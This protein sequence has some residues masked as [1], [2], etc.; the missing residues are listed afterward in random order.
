ML[1]EKNWKG[2]FIIKLIQWS[3]PIHSLKD[4]DIVSIFQAMGEQNK[5][6]NQIDQSDSLEN[7][8]LVRYYY[9]LISRLE[10]DSNDYELLKTLLLLR[11]GILLILDKRV[12]LTILT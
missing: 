2:L 10:L 6:F 9:T 3:V 1:I 7:F 4:Q 8:N 11:I 5:E 12:F